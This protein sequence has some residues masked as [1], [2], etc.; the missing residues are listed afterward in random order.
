MKEPLED[1]ALFNEMSSLIGEEE[2]TKESK[3][4]KTQLPIQVDKQSYNQLLEL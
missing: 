4:G 3:G 1:R 2:E